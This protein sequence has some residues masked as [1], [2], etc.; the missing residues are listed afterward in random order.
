MTIKELD[1]VASVATV[2]GCSCEILALEERLW[3]VAFARVFILHLLVDALRCVSGNWWSHTHLLSGNL[4]CVLAKCDLVQGM[5]VT[6][7][8]ELRDSRVGSAIHV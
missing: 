8:A 4:I 2:I 3:I 6:N 1:F 7:K 5:W